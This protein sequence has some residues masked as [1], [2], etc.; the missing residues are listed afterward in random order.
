MLLS[1]VLEPATER[2]NVTGAQGGVVRTSSDGSHV[3]FVAHGV[4]TPEENPYKKK[5]KPGKANLY[6]YDTVTK[7][8]K[9][10]ATAGNSLEFDIEQGEN[11]AVTSFTIDNNDLNRHAQTTPNGRFL[12]FSSPAKIADAREP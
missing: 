12:V 7:Q 8:L 1:K 11:K 5:A 6:A 4:L 10:V 3:Y 2:A 9:F